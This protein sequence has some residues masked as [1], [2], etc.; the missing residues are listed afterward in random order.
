MIKSKSPEKTFMSLIDE[1]NDTEGNSSIRN[2]SP[3]PS[4]RP[5]SRMGKFS[6]GLIDSDNDHDHNHDDDKK[7][8]SE[9]LS[10][11]S[12]KGKC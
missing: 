5:K 9:S 7:S 10:R 6:E 12:K 2:S 8:D 3:K 4:N 11:T 1:G